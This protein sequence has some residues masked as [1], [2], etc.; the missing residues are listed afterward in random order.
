MKRLCRWFFAAA[1]CF[2]FVLCA[3]VVVLWVRCPS[4][5]TY[6]N[7]ESF[8]WTHVR[9]TQLLLAYLLS[10]DQRIEVALNSIHWVG[11]IPSPEAARSFLW[12][13]FHGFKHS[14][15]NDMLS[16][17]D[18]RHGFAY[19]YEVEDNVDPVDKSNYPEVTLTGSTLRRS[20]LI[21]GAPAWALVLTTGA[22]PLWMV[23]RTVRR[24]RM[25]K[26]GHCPVCGYDMRATPDRCPECGAIPP[27]NQSA[28][29]KPN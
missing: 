26:P 29:P 5:S 2:S 11:K 28:S 10:Q 22:L 18:F 23:V 1:A 9:R 16:E 21:L 15:D 3:G 12:S 8:G 13:P 6:H 14:Y 4:K 20:I 25:A 24:W 17:R 19:F 27:Q 7:C